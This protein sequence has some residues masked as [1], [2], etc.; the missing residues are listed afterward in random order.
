MQQLR[1]GERWKILQ[2]NVIDVLREIPDEVV[3]T[4][5]TSPPYWG[6]R[7]Y[8]TP[9][10]VWG[11]VSDCDHNFS[12]ETNPR[13]T[14]YSSD[15]NEKSAKQTTNKG[16]FEYI[17]SGK[18][19][20]CSKC[21]AW[22]GSL[23]HEPTPQMFVENLVI[24]FREMRRVLRKD[25]TFWLNIGD[26][27]AGSSG[28][29]GGPGLSTKGKRA[30]KTGTNKRLRPT[31]IEGLKPKD[32]VGIPWSLAEALRQ[33]YYTGRI[34][35]ELDRAWIAA[36]MDGQ[37]TICG[38]EHNRSDDESLRTGISVCITNSNIPLLDEVER[39]WHTSKRG[40]NVHSDN[41]FGERI[42]YRWIVHGVENK[43]LF[44]REIYP[45][46]IAKKK[47]AL[48]AYNFLEFSKKAKS[49]A[50]SK[51]AESI[52]QK[53]LWL[54]RS[55]S[56]L[57]HGET[58]D[59][60]NWVKEPPILYEKGWYLRCDNVWAK[61]NPMVESVKD[62]CTR[63][64]EYI[65]HFSKSRKYFYDQD[66]V[67]NAPKPKYAG[68]KIGL[69]PKRK[70]TLRNDGGRSF[71]VNG[72]KGANKRSVWTFSTNSFRG[73]HYASFPEELA[74]APILAGSRE[75]DIVLDPFSGSGTTGVVALRFNRKYIGIELN[76]EYI[77]VSEERIREDNEI[78]LL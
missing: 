30:E 64:H 44:L 16:S 4:V 60:P 53:R 3:Q 72:K 67:R 76:D 14:R 68:K 42:V 2:G 75:N 46:L 70:G 12:I 74:T 18:G 45:Y 73:G 54:V 66:A 10:Q 43:S 32:L 57:N 55:I 41:H 31:K 1:E 19:A 5:V 59:I 9:P 11:G 17:E 62:R 69:A 13:R 7:N 49:L 58:V 15:F 21:G 52:K 8:G 22:I 37:G 20:M 24:I 61:S 47:Q 29:S 78:R 36:M 25:G 38:F 50:R 65:F 23:G 28:A 39:I 35:N 27:Y 40:K 51:E 63:C 33:P 48:L 6:A 56:K 77:K 26:C 34:R 71:Q